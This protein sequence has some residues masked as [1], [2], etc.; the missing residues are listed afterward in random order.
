MKTA[1]R[2]KTGMA[3]GS[4]VYT[5]TKN[6][7][8]VRMHAITFNKDA[9]TE[10]ECQSVEQLPLC[11]D[12]SNVAWI[13]V[14]G[15]H[16]VSLIEQ[17]GAKYGIHPLTI[18][19]ILHVGQRPKIEEFDDYV[20]VVLWMMYAGADDIVQEQVSFIVTDTCVITLQEQPGDVFDP[21]R[22]RIRS[23][24]Y[25]INSSQSDY[26]AYALIDMAVDS[27]YTV[28]ENVD[29]IVTDL[30]ER[31]L[32]DTSTRV[33]HDLYQM[34]RRI[35]QIRRALWP[36]R[37]VASKLERTETK[38]VKKATRIYFRDIY[39]HTIQVIDTV[40][41][42]RDLLSGLLD[43]Y[44]SSASNKMNE[45]MKVLT[46]IATLFIPLTFIAGIYGMNFQHMPELSWKYG[47][48][49]VWGVMALSAGLMI[50][51]FK[52]RKWL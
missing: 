18:E 17:I 33:L 37:E 47:Y 3:P 12:Q 39:D 28:M 30:E 29:E 51:Y 35:L 45:V 13:D 21:V 16:S 2:K 14:C 36:L 10:Y 15:L 38:L 43:T 49:A 20:Y 48:L 22:E 23:R 1:A 19:D 24:K 44:L 7:E 42:Y 11:K 5:G 46:I 50:H 52:R 31:V 32:V 6:T 34:K 26:L 27:Y 25:R 9:V 40:E 8:P 4:A 41:H